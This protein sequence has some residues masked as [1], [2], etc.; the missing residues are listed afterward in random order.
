MKSCVGVEIVEVTA[1][2]DIVAECFENFWCGSNDFKIGTELLKAPNKALR[3]M[4][5]PPLDGWSIDHYT[6]YDPNLSVHYSLA[7]R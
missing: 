1:Y 2:S 5:N 3:Y 4:Y 7:Y 6:Q